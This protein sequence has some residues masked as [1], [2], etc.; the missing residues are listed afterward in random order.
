M[1]QSALKHFR[2]FFHVSTVTFAVT[3]MSRLSTQFSVIRPYTPR[4]SVYVVAYSLFFPSPKWP[5]INSL[6]TCVVRMLACA[7]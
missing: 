3:N 7:F 2:N 6:L 1:F 4:P 5:I